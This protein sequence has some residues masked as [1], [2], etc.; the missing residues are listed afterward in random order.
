[1][2]L[3]T[4]HALGGKPMLRAAVQAAAS[5]RL[6][7]VTV[8]TS[9]A[10]TDYWEATGRSADGPLDP[11]VERLVRMAIDS[12]VGAVVASPLEVRRIASL[13]GPGRWVVTPGIRLPG[14]PEDDQRRT[15]TPAEAVAAGATHLVIGRP[16]TRA[17]NPRAV[18][19]ALCEEIA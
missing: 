16:I 7:A 2:D 3:A 10:P 12:G 9:H 8:L 17:E 4:V 18:Y 13:A 19:D 15:A 6:A 5:L 1:V 11:E 14:S